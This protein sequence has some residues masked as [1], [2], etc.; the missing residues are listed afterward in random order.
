MFNRFV[1][2]AAMIVALALPAITAFAQGPFGLMNQANSSPTQ[3]NPMRLLRHPEVQVAI[4]LSLMQ[5]K[6]I[7][8]LRDKQFVKMQQQMQQTFQQARQQTRTANPQDRQAQM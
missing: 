2:Q 1:R 7:D 6:K 8:D 5:R 4:S 3:P